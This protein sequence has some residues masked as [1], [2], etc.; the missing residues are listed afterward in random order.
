MW[1]FTDVCLI[2]LKLLK[3]TA[4]QLSDSI[5]SNFRMNSTHRRNTTA[6]KVIST[7][8]G[9]TYNWPLLT[10]GPLIQVCV[11]LQWLN[12]NYQY[13]LSKT[14]GHSMLVTSMCI[15]IRHCNTIKKTFQLHKSIHTEIKWLYPYCNRFNVLSL[16]LDWSVKHI[17]TFSTSPGS[18]YAKWNV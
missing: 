3:R 18:R 5:N 1:K 15:I 6:F 12:W 10:G 14:D 8:P 13:W 17:I 16:T 4:F 11:M 2:I 9:D 7:H